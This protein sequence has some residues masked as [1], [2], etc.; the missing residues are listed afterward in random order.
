MAVVMFALSVTVY[1]IF[2][3]EIFKSLI[4]ETYTSRSSTTMSS[5]TSMDGG[6]WPRSRWEK[7][8]DLSQTVFV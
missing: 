4:Y 7:M 3:D 6:L 2:A 5:N 8:L 1:V